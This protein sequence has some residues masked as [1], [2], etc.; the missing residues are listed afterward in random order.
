MPDLVTVP[1]I[2]ALP[3]QVHLVMQLKMAGARDVAHF[4][5][6]YLRVAYVSQHVSHLENSCMLLICHGW[7]HGLCK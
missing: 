6:D 2:E 4:L 1:S 3:Q 7:P 5:W